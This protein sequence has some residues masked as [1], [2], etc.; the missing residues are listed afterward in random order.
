MHL[1]ANLALVGQLCKTLDRASVGGLPMLEFPIH[2]CRSRRHALSSLHLVFS[3]RT[4][5]DQLSLNDIFMRPATWH[6][7]A[8]GGRIDESSNPLVSWHAITPRWPSLSCPHGPMRSLSSTLADYH[9]PTQGWSSNGKVENFGESTVGWSI[10][11]AIQP[12][13][14]NNLPCESCFLNYCNVA[15]NWDLICDL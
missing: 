8:T 11:I 4:K 10:V 5:I 12:P 7:S 13:M 14:A 1:N 6:I 3:S 2:T 9:C 15:K